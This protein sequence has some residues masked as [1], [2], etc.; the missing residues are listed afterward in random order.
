MVWQCE[1]V[2]PSAAWWIQHNNTINLPQLWSATTATQ[3]TERLIQSKAV[4]S[5]QFQSCKAIKTKQP[6][7]LQ[8]KTAKLLQYGQTIITTLQVTMSTKLLIVV[9]IYCTTL[10]YALLEQATNKSSFD[11]RWSHDGQHGYATIIS[12]WMCA[13]D[14][15]FF[16]LHAFCTIVCLVF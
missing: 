2:F 4:L 12:C 3:R 15:V 16:Y 13:D 8:K 9:P 10:L 14:F 7:M 6:T 11:C 5:F 1:Y